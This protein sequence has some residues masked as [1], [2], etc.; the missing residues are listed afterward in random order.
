M[1]APDVIE[2]PTARPA[3]ACSDMVVRLT[4]EEIKLLCVAVTQ[5]ADR[6]SQDA[7]HWRATAKE[8]EERSQS[9]LMWIK[10]AIRYERE[11]RKLYERS[12]ELRAIYRQMPHNDEL[13]GPPTRDVARDS[14]T[15][16]AN[17]G[18]QQ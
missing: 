4:R 15:E 14:G 18:S 7:L 17:G 1:N 11:A 12:R 5:R 16:S 9:Q 8:R 13:C 2:Q 3:V 10:T 6:T